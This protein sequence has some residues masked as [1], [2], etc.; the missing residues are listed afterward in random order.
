MSL[1]CFT[2]LLARVAKPGDP[3]P[4]TQS[5]TEERYRVLS[6]S[7]AGQDCAEQKR[8]CSKIKQHAE[9]VASLLPQVGLIT[10]P[11]SA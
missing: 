6:L 9:A 2:D 7:E 3:P 10:S 1:S 4:Q 11:L 8:S 5:L